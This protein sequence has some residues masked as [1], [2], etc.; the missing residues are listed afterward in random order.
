VYRGA[1]VGY[2]AD[3][4]G[5][6]ARGPVHVVIGNGGAALSTNVPLEPSPIWQAR[7]CARA[8]CALGPRAAFFAGRTCFLPL[9]TH[10][11]ASSIPRKASPAF[12]ARGP[13]RP[14][15][16]PAVGCCRPPQPPPQPPPN[17]P[18]PPPTA[19][20]RRQVIKF[21]W[22]YLRVEATATKLAA[23]AVSDLDGRP[24]DAFEL[25]KPE[26]WGPAFMA[27]RAAARRGGG[28]GGPA[29]G[30]GGGGPAAGGGAGGRP[31]AAA[32]VPS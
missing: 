16:A 31:G 8:R 10:P 15:A 9:P 25:R 27:A 20:N 12:R 19:P 23:E 21:W 7:S 29:A 4:D 32:A 17:R 5:G 28:G 18:Q 24:L 22:G 2:D 14:L 11:L 3:A 13:S 6:A 26:G 1:C 30:G